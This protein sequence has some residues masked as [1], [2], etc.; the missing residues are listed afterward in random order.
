VGS[1]SEEVLRRSNV[2]VLIVTREM[3]GGCRSDREG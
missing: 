1:V 2:P 3:Q